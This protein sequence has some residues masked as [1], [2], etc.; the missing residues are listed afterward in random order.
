MTELKAGSIIAERYRITGR[1]GEGAA[2]TVYEARDL[3]HDRRVAVKVLRP[4]VVAWLGPPRFLQE[5]RIT[6]GIVHPHVLPVFDSG[7][8]DGLLFYVMPFAE[9]S[10]LRELM[11][12]EGQLPLRRVVELVRQVAAGLEAAHSRDV[13]HRDIKPENVLFLSGH[14]ALGD[15]GVA[16]ALNPS[17]GV[18]RTEG[19]LV[20]GTPT[21]MSPEV[22]AGDQEIGPAADQYSLACIAYELLAGTPPFTAGSTRALIARHMHDAVP[23][24]TTVRPDLPPA[25]GRV[26]ERSLAKL[27]G[28]RFATITDFAQAMEAAAEGEDTATM[29]SLAVLPFANLGGLPDDET[30]CSGIAEEV[31]STLTRIEGLRVASRTSSF[32][33]KDKPLDIRSIGSQLH[34]GAVLEGSVRRSGDRLR[35]AVKLVSAE[36]GYLLWSERYDRELS[37]VFAIQDDIAQSVA[38][39]L[40]VMLGSGAGP[41]LSP[42]PTGN[43]RAYEYFLRGRQYLWRSRRQNL[44]FASEMFQRALALDPEFAPAWAGLAYAICSIDMYYPGVGTDLS[45]AT[46]ASERA[47]AAAPDLPVAHTARAFVLWRTGDDA[48][49]VEE[50]EAVHRMDPK[51]F[52]ACYI[53][54]RMRFQRGE[55]EKAAELFDAATSA[56]EDYQARFFAAQAFAALGRG[57]EAE[58]AYRRALHVLNQHLELNPDDARAATMKAVALCRLGQAEEGLLWAERARGLDPAD[59]GVLY[60]VACLYALE[61]ASDRALDTLEAAVAAGFGTRDWIEHDPDLDSL[62][63]HPRFKALLWPE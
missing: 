46:R 29:R 7:E 39:A 42:I 21:Y 10:S 1:L 49:A 61:G 34:V 37:D 16:H 24:L 55:M 38:R 4:D 43:V 48:A 15:F 31:I 5:I 11:Q 59:I 52:E 50:F 13:V 63:D 58:A 45:A 12:R 41:G 60:N 33:F 25:V 44:E 2:A 19:G 14:A 57:A 18:P 30:L 47:L 20:F 22:C 32:A 62:R 35:V 26:I 28:D 8:S 54:G 53:H 27:P 36:D 6:A 51:Q 17:P 40:R 23:P 9:G 3:R 56:Q